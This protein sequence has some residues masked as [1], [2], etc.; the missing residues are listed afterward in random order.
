MLSLIVLILE[1]I[2][3]LEDE[4]TGTLLSIYAVFNQIKHV[5]QMK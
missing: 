2:A 4:D 1:G 5:R 3:E